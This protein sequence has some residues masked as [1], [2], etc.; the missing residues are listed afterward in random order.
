[1]DID[2]VAFTGS[3]LTGR[4]ILKASAAS[5]LKKVTLELGGKSPNI[6]FPDADLEQAVEWSAWGINMNYG[7]TCHAGTRIYVHADIYDK[8]CQS[9]TARMKKLVVGDN[10]DEKTDQGP[11]NSKIQYDK[12]LSYLESGKKEG[13]TVALGGNAHKGSEG[14]G[15]Y[16]EPTIFT[17]VNPSMKIVQDEIFGPVVTIH[18]FT[19]E[20]DVIRQA[21]DT[22]YGLAAGIHTKD[23]A[24]AVRVTNK[25]KAGTC[26]V[27]LFNFVH[28]SLP[29]G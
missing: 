10:F 24:R 25:L 17:D 28:W 16:I 11:Q 9:F 18:K 15:Y 2:K 22:T 7:Q 19:D 12:I 8:F 1:M 14:G 6:V 23:Y 3:T 21:N 4:N 5:N 29:F 26:W 13:A 27:N 20:K